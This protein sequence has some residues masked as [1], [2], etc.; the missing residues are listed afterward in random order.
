MS[1]RSIDPSFH[2]TGQITPSQLPE[3]AGLGFRTV[4]C[5]RPDKEG[6]S[7]PSFD[8]IAEA[9]RGAGIDAH[10]IPVVPG[11]ISLEQAQRLKGILS[12]QAGPILAYCASGQRCAAAYEMAKR[13]P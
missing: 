8:Q 3:I 9:A 11:Q 10:Y 13:V 2:V 5:M 7:Q 1:I 6:F 4:I 12:G